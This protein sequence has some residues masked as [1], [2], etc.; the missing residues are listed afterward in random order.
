MQFNDFEKISIASDAVI[1]SYM[2]YKGHISLM[3][4]LVR[5]NEEPFNNMWSLPGGFIDA[6]KGLQE[7]LEN[8]IKSKTGLVKIYS[9]Q[10]YTYGDDVDRDP[11]GRVISVGYI[12]PVSPDTKIIASNAEWFR[13]APVS[14]NN[15]TIIDVKIFSKDNSM[16]VDSLAFDHKKILI[17]ALNR[18]RG[19]VLYSNLAFHM[20]RK[21]FTLSDAQELYECILGKPFSAFR[22][23]VSD[24]VKATNEFWYSSSKRPSRLYQ[25]EEN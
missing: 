16:S 2:W 11:R 12:V 8:K 24:K 13:L 18:V 23:F 6:D 5:R 1:L 10:L 21:H 3:V 7:A 19:K 14:D 20:M 17:D 9:E 4:Q 22:R 25:I 15:N